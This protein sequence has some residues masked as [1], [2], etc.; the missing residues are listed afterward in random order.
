M[1]AKPLTAATPWAAWAQQE[2]FRTERDFMRSLRNEPRLLELIAAFED[3]DRLYIVR[4]LR[5]GILA[6][7]CTLTCGL[8]GR[9]A[10]R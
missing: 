7:G 1:G 2:Q 9:R 3:A 4:L 8:V 10:S 5:Q 6:G